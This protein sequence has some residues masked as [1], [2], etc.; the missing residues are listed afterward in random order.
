MSASK[1]KILIKS[2][3]MRLPFGCTVPAGDCVKGRTNVPSIQV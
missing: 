2:M 1:V 3:T